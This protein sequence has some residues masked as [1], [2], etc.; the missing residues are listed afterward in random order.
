[1]FQSL[2]KRRIICPLLNSRII[3][4]IPFYMNLFECR[5]GR[6]RILDV[7]FNNTWAVTIICVVMSDEGHFHISKQFFSNKKTDLKPFLFYWNFKFLSKLIVNTFFD[8]ASTKPTNIW[9][10]LN[11]KQEV[12]QTFSFGQLGFQV[13]DL[14]F[15]SLILTRRCLHL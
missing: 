4:I 10:Q 7:C 15:V 8:E 1:M 13:C 2:C 14:D 6:A 12:T 11:W 5:E 3:L 9:I